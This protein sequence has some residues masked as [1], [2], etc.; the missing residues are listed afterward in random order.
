MSNVGK[1]IRILRTQ[2]KMTQN[3][4]A[5]RLFVSRQT[6]S[7]YENGK[8]CPD[9]QML[10]KI[11]EALETDVHTLIYGPNKLSGSKRE[12][13]KAIIS[14]I[15][16][17]LSGIVAFLFLEKKA[18]YELYYYF[19]A[20][21][22]YLQEAFLPFFY[23]ALGWTLMQFLGTGCNL[24]PLKNKSIRRFS[25][26]IILLLIIIPVLF[27]PHILWEKPPLPDFPGK[28]WM[29]AAQKVLWGLNRW[30]L[31]LLFIFGGIILWLA[32]PHNRRAP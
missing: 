1:N 12:L 2:N 27:L 11:S 15:I 4:L 29:S 25:Y 5:E 14:L 28:Y 16:T 23:T 19:T 6:I 7:N 18:E 17:I 20:R 10:V 32:P 26:L 21:F 9:I 24:K 3:E 30:K 8:S 13:Q 31:N 22:F